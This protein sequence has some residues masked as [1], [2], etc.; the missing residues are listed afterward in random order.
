MK[1]TPPSLMIAKKSS[2]T[3]Y[4][5]VDSVKVP[6]SMPVLVGGQDR[7]GKLVDVPQFVAR[8]LKQAMLTYF[9]D[10]QVVSAGTPFGAAPYAVADVR[11]DRVEVLVTGRRTSGMVVTSA[12]SAA[13]S[14][15]FGLRVGEADEYL[16]SFAGE[17]AGMPGE[18]PNFVFRS[19]F[20]SAITDLL[21]GYSDKGIHQKILEQ[22]P[23]APATEKPSSI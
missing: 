6:P 9:N 17:S 4:I 15:G 7:G 12:G 8:D 5:V 21:K 22:Q 18:E 2:R 3:L 14:W 13:L 20:E 23:A 11:L 19:M 16:Y 10:V 1:V